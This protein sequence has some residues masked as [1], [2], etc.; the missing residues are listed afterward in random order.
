MLLR[1]G[2]PL[3]A[4]DVFCV[5]CTFGMIAQ[6]K[7]RPR[8]TKLIA[9]LNNLPAVAINRGVKR[10][11]PLSRYPHYL[12]EESQHDPEDQPYVRVI[13]KTVYLLAV[14]QL[15]VDPAGC[16]GTVSSS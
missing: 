6:A 14:S 5:M 8:I 7:I 10:F 9:D 1:D 11:T 15:P 2:A 3:P 13:E 12:P 4:V 16:K